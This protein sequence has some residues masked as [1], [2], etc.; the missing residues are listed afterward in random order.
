MPYF[1]FFKLLP[2]GMYYLPV[3]PGHKATKD[4][5]AKV[6]MFIVTREIISDSFIDSAIVS[7]VQTQRTVCPTA[8]VHPAPPTAANG[9]YCA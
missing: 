5:P 9:E 8:H 2:I 6:C 4:W 3:F 1:L 7:Q